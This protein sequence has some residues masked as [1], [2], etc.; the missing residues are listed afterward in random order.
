MGGGVGSA[1]AGGVA[2][3]SGRAFSSKKGKG[4]KK[5]SPAMQNYN[6]SSLRSQLEAQKFREDTNP[7]VLHEG[8]ESISSRSSR[9]VSG[10]STLCPNSVGSMWMWG[11]DEDECRGGLGRYFGRFCGFGMNFDFGPAFR[12]I[13][14]EVGKMEL[15]YGSCVA[16]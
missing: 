10:R 5:K 16:T 12:K 7:N 1:G 2:P 3:Q 13:I 9:D 15:A 14:C 6:Y 4:N 8:P 11:K